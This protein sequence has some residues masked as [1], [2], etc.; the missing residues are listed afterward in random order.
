MQ[1]KWLPACQHHT[2]LFLS[3][4]SS[5]PPLQGQE[6]EKIMLKSRGNS[7]LNSYTEILAW[8]SSLCQVLTPE[9]LTQPAT[10]TLG[11]PPYKDLSLEVSP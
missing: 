3:A 10:R 9:F 5:Y 1:R 6:D 11:A 8:K 2:F 4:P 7:N